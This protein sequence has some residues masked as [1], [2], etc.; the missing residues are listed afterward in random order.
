MQRAQ[1]EH[2]I[3]N[4]EQV[5]HTHRRGKPP[6]HTG[7]DCKARIACNQSKANSATGHHTDGA[8]ERK[9][10]STYDWK[11]SNT[12][13]SE[14]KLL[15]GQ[16]EHFNEPR[17][18]L[19]HNSGMRHVTEGIT[20]TSSSTALGKRRFQDPHASKQ[21][22]LFPSPQCA[23]S[24]CAPLPHYTPTSCNHRRRGGGD[25]V[26]QARVRQQHLAMKTQTNVTNSVKNSIQTA[27]RDPP[28]PLIMSLVVLSWVAVGAIVRLRRWGCGGV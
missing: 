10:I 6:Y 24:K 13:Q 9:N 12:R 20:A 28:L 18:T 8:V 23:A 1:C 16:A 27:I 19:Q 22:E 4:T 25:F 3:S 26:L 17:R 5:I 15:T 11:G 7:T 14:L 21:R 2:K